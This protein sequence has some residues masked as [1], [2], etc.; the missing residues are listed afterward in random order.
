MPSGQGK[1]KKPKTPK[2]KATKA[3]T[4][5]KRS[6]S[7]R[8][9]AK[10]KGTTQR[11][12]AMA[13]PESAPCVDAEDARPLVIGCI[14][15]DVDD[16]TQLGVLFPDS[17]VRNDFCDCVARKSKVPRNQIPCGASTTVQGVIDAITCDD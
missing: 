6:E 4:G 8:S 13:A 17:D 15:H 5:K 14:G 9:A 16:E 11:A 1:R 2:R 3:K 10:S 7:R 12:K